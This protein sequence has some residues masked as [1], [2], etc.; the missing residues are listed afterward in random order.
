[1][2]NVRMFR[3][4]ILVVMSLSFGLLSQ[5][6]AQTIG[7][8]TGASPAANFL[9]PLLKRND[10]QNELG[11]DDRQKDALTKVF[12][13]KYAEVPLVSMYRDISNLSDTERKQWQAEVNREASATAAR[14]YDDRRRQ[15]EEILRPGQRERLTELDLQWRGILALGDKNLSDK[16]GISPAHHQ[17]I[18]EIVDEFEGSR[19]SLYSKRNDPLRYQRLLQETEPRVFAILSAEEKSRW[20][21]A[22]GRPFVFEK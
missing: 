5:I 2:N 15:L 1:M 3:R 21:H 22:I 18:S 7:P 17:R 16:L 10:V 20:A 4:T 9:T 8:L 19:V 11:L 14:I 12:R 6:Q 13:V